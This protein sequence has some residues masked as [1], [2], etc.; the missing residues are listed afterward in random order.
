MRSPLSCHRASLAEQGRVA[1]S[2]VV[3]L[4]LLVGAAVAAVM[5]L[6]ALGLLPTGDQAPSASPTLRDSDPTSA[7]T[8]S[9]EAGWRDGVGLALPP[10]VTDVDGRE[11]QSREMATWIWEYVDDQWDLLI[12]SEGDGDVNAD[13]TINDVQVMYLEAPD[14]E[15]FRLN[16]LRRDYTLEVVQWDP[17]LALAW[18]RYADREVLAPV[19]QHDLRAGEVN[20]SWSGGAVSSTNAVA[21][22][23]ANVAYVGDQPDGRELWVSY[24]LS[25]LATG[26]FWRE[27]EDFAGSVMNSELNRLRL[28][29]FTDDQGVDAWLDPESMTAVYRATY[30][31]D[32]R[33]DEE[34][35][36]LHDLSDDRFQDVNPQV[37]GSSDCRPARDITDAGQFQGERIVA[38]C[39]GDTVLIDPTGDSAPQ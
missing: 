2:T 1:V 3:T 8:A 33:V 27:A 15:L 29:G 30:R 34:R 21:G 11:P 32:G 25:G 37:P 10:Y 16:E 13:N 35:W 14:G 22:G 6:H 18:L 26:I 20:R 19:V 7:P 4:V 28:Q 17:E 9:G 36:I 12:V 24:D 39:D 23:I 5:G 31:I 38:T